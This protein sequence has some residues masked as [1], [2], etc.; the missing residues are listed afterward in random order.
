MFE[1]IKGDIEAVV[2]RDP[3]AR[4]RLEVLLC[5]PG[6]HARL[7]HRLAHALWRRGWM[8]TARFVVA[9]RPLARPA[10]RSTRPR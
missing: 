9:H 10:S 5:Y 6:I 3:A 4:S 2:E 8:L 1:D 7:V